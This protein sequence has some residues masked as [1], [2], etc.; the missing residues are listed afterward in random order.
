MDDLDDVD[1]IDDSRVCRCNYEEDE[2]NQKILVGYGILA[3]TSVLNHIPRN[4]TLYT[5]HTSQTPRP[6]STSPYLGPSNKSQLQ[7]RHPVS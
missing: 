3:E 2:K 4:I 1:E 5:S 7:S 6:P